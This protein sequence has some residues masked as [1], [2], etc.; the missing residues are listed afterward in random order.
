M[1]AIHESGRV[2]LLGISNI[3]REQLPRLCD[4]ARVRPSFVQNH[5]YADQG[6]DRRV[7]EYCAAHQ[8]VYQGFSLLTANRVALA[9]PAVARIAKRHQRTPS[10]IMFRFALDVGMIP[11][12]G[13]SSADHMREDLGVFDFRLP[14]EDIEQIEHLAG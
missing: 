12:T 6:W 14:Q 10:Q 11:L 7:R 13:T 3:S 5:C 2:R 9:R 4:Q 8:L 1:E